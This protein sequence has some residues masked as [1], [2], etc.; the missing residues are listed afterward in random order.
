M[1]AESRRPDVAVGA[2]VTGTDGA[3]IGRVDAVFV[4]YLLV[5]SFGIVPVDIYL[6]TAAA[7]LSA[8]DVRVDAT[9]QEA[10][11]RWHRPLKSVAHDAER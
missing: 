6:P 1:S 2:T 9:P 5:R 10:Y 3:R 4:D 7:E 11:Q 8:N